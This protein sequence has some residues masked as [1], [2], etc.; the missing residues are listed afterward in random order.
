M[1]TPPERRN[2]KISALILTGSTRMMPKLGQVRH[3]H[4]LDG[5]LVSVARAF[6]LQFGQY[7]L[8]RTPDW[9]VGIGRF[10]LARARSNLAFK[11]VR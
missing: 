9:K 3:Y 5:A 10:G 8:R 2:A 6:S 7:L 11:R 4:V 1:E